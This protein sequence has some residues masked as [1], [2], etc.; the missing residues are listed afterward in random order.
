MSIE[1]MWYASDPYPPKCNRLIRMPPCDQLGMAL[2]L[3][4]DIVTQDAGW[5]AYVN[6]VTGER[7]WYWPRHQGKHGDWW[8]LPSRTEKLARRAIEYASEIAQRRPSPAWPPEPGANMVDWQLI[9]LR[10]LQRR[11]YKAARAVRETELPP[12][13]P[14]T[15]KRKKLRE[16]ITPAWGDAGF[17]AR[18]RRMEIIAEWGRRGRPQTAQQWRDRG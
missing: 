3:A 2:D 17:E 1:A 12:R 4:I 7:T 8:M 13:E 18:C 9:V 6:S 10:R 14:L 15:P 11:A 5:R 16:T